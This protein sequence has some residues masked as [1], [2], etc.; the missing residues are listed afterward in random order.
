MKTR[1][2]FLA[3]VLSFITLNI[4]AQT[5]SVTEAVFIAESFL[6]NRGTLRAQTPESLSLAYTAKSQLRTAPEKNY[7]YV[8]NRSENNGFIIVSADSRAIDVL[9]YA[10]Q[11]AFDYDNLPE[12]LKL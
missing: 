11:G 9:G 6:S 2:L 1:I 7:F 4:T 8:F 12:N 10:D 3:W 5:R